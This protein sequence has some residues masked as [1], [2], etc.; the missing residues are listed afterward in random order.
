MARVLIFFSSW[1]LPTLYL[2]SWL[3]RLAGEARV[4]GHQVLVLQDGEATESNLIGALNSY[5]PEYVIIGGHGNSNVITTTN[6]QVLLK[7]CT[8]D[9]MLAGT[10]VVFVSCLTGRELVPSVVRKGAL[11]AAGFTEEFVWTVSPPFLPEQD[12]FAKPFERVINDPI[13]ELFNT[14]SVR[15]WFNKYVDVS[16]EE[17]RAWGVVDPVAYPLAPQVVLNLRS[18]R[19]AATFVGDGESEVAGDG[20]GLF[21]VGLAALLASGL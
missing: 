3:N 2:S 9:G 20:G 17:E 21:I 5:F 16:L 4:Q 18:N 7:G 19:R 15:A 13:L 11:G 6:L 14:G 10:R 1:D 8:N 12:V